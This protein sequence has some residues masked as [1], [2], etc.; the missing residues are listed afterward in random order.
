MLENI[1][2]QENR[3]DLGWKQRIVRITFDCF[4]FFIFRY[5][6]RNKKLMLMKLMLI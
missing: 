3:R 1:R 6:L 2:S 4:F 5:C